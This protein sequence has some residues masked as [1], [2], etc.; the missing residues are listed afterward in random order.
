MIPYIQID[1]ITR[2]TL[3]EPITQ[4][5]ISGASARDEKALFLEDSDTAFVEPGK[6]LHHRSVLE[7]IEALIDGL[8]DCPATADE[9]LRT[10]IHNLEMQTA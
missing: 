6:Y 1:T 8:V 3:G 4:A 5:Y 9:S 7:L 10:L 2:P